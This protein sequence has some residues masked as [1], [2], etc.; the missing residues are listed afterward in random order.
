MENTL[1]SL[2]PLDVLYKQFELTLPPYHF[3]PAGDIPLPQV[4]LLAHD[5]DMTPTVE[6]YYKQ[7]VNLRVIHKIVEKEY[8]MRMVTLDCKDGRKVVYGAIR[9]HMMRFPEAAR[10]QIIACRQPLGSILSE[11]PLPHI[12]KPQRF[13]RILSDTPINT[14]LDLPH[15]EW[16]FG[17]V[18][19]LIG[20]NRLPLVEVVEILPPMAP[21][22]K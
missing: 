13:M 1:S 17:R 22:Q 4:E 11:H 8:L 3:I 5:A 2:Y 15:Q 12:S 18:N 16:L 10:R 6:A 14:A 19:R 20:K 9:I 7:K 21:K